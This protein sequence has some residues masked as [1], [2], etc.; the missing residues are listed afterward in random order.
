MSVQELTSISVPTTTFN[1]NNDDFYA[2]QYQPIKLPVWPVWSGVIGKF[3]YNN[4]FIS[5]LF[6]STSDG[7]AKA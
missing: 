4:K 5:T 2:I 1:R 7:M 6:I 3:I